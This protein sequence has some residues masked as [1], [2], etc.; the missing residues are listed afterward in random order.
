MEKGKLELLKVREMLGAPEY[1]ASINCLN[2][3]KSYS[4][5]I[6]MG[7]LIAQANIPCSHCGCSQEQVHEY[8][9]LKREPRLV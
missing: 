9:N 3:G 8:Y 1:S 2:C 7:T 4:V 5:K 6:P